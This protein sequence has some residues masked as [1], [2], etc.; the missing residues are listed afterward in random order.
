MRPGH[1]RAQGERGLGVEQ[2]QPVEAPAQL[3]PGI[4]RVARVER[5]REAAGVEVAL[6]IRRRVEALRLDRRV[7]R[8]PAVDGGEAIAALDAAAERL[9]VEARSQMIA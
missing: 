4:G 5:E 8:E 3:A 7:R 1:A 2:Q 9:R 6:I